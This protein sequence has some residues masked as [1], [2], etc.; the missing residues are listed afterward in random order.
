MAGR[1]KS[2]YIVYV[3]RKLEHYGIRGKAKTWIANIIWQIDLNM[4]NLKKK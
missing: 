2:Q 3:I 4:F 1:D